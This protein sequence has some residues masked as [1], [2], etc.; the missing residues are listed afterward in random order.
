MDDDKEIHW[1]FRWLIAI[2]CSLC[3]LVMFGISSELP[4]PL[5]GYGLGV[6]G[7]LVAITCIMQGKIRILACSLIAVA[8]LCL[9]VFYIS[10]EIASGKLIS[11][12]QS[13]PSVLNSLLFMLV[14]GIPSI[15]YLYKYK[16]G[17]IFKNKNNA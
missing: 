12:S 14:Y 8:V 15:G 5:F 17:I 11:S 10:A 13:E 6:L 3:A 7:I 4:E 2:F 9:G 1:F 16:F